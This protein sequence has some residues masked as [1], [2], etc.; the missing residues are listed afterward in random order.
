MPAISNGPK[1]LYFPCRLMIATWIPI[2]DSRQSGQK[3]PCMPVVLRSAAAGRSLSFAHISEAVARKARIRRCRQMGR[4]FAKTFQNDGRDTKPIPAARSSSVIGSSRHR[5]TLQRPGETSLP[6]QNMKSGRIIDRER[7]KG[8]SIIGAEGLHPCHRRLD[9]KC[10]SHPREEIKNRGRERGLPQ[11]SVVEIMASENIGVRVRDRC[12]LASQL[13]GK[14]QQ[15][16]IS[17]GQCR[18]IDITAGERTRGL[19]I[20]GSLRPQEECVTYRSVTAP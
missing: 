19:M 9:A 5:Q 16:A 8:K 4:N 14:C 12:W 11:L 13:F 7:D 3:R 17:Q 2:R 10:L 6:A 18:A 20:I 1:T 15:C